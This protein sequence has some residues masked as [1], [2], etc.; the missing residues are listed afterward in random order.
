MARKGAAEQQTTALAVAEPA[1]IEVRGGNSLAV[2]D[3]FDF[4][5]NDGLS[6]VDGSDLRLPLITFNLKGPRP[7]G[8]LH[9]LNEFYDTLGDKS[10]RTIKCAFVHLHKTNLFS[11]FNQAKNETEIVCSSHDR[12]TGT[13]RMAHLGLAERTE[14]PCEKCPDA[15]WGRDANTGKPTKNCADVYGAFGVLLDENSQPTEGFLIR[16]KKTSLQ[17]FKT[18]MQ[19]HHLNR[20]RLPNGKMA[21]VPLFAFGVSMTLAVDKSGNF[22][23][24]VLEKLD[25]LPRETIVALAEQSKFLAEVGDEATKAAERQEAKHESAIDTEGTSSSRDTNLSDNDFVGSGG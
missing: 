5:D 8:T 1:D 24:P 25:V 15:Q 11:R 17:P 4:G 9:Q 23:V 3:D 21:H 20:R 14:R 12:V 13:L 7:D 19:K 10:Y 22:A 18:H 16:F 6:E 2:L